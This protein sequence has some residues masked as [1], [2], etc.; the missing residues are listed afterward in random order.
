MHTRTVPGRSSQCALE[1]FHIEADLIGFYTWEA[2]LEL[3]ESP[4]I[5]FYPLMTVLNPGHF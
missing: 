1:T 4:D 2:F 3:V 5:Y